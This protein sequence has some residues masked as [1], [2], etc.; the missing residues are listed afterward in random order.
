MKKIFVIFVLILLSLSKVDAACV[1][2]LTVTGTRYR[3]NGHQNQCL[4]YIGGY[5]TEGEGSV[6]SSCFSISTSPIVIVKLDGT[7]FCFSP[8]A[9]GNAT[10]TITVAADCSCSGEAMSKPISFKLSEWGLRSLSI[11]G[12]DI[13]PEFNNSKY[14]YTATV[15]NNVTSVE[16]NP[17]AL[18]Y[19]SEIKVTGNDNLQVGENK[20][21]INVVTP[22][23]D[24][25]DYFITVI[26]NEFDGVSGDSSS[27]DSSS[28]GSSSSDSSSS[29]SSFS[30]SSSDSL[31]SNNNPETGLNYMYFVFGLGIISLVYI[32]WHLK[33]INISEY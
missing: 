1:K 6:S 26:R 13:S 33:N 23:G 11:T 4:P 30:G 17:V 12:Y 15:P 10:I 19:D 9:H 18:D 20:V 32:V 21:K 16:I 5:T 3:T 2:D 8:Q 22:Q 29:D 27:S 25:R 31:T 24:S 28:S 14:E 7:N